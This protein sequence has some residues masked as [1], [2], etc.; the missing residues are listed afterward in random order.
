VVFSGK[1]PFDFFGSPPAPS[2][3]ECP[4]YTFFSETFELCPIRDLVGIL[5]IPAILAYALWAIMAL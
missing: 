1:F 5:K 4:N 3:P 2:I